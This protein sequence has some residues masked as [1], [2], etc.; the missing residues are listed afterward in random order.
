V[1]APL[2][3]EAG[4][5]EAWARPLALGAVIVVITYCSLI[6]GELAPKAIALRNPER[7]AAFVARPI[8][9]LSRLS[10]LPVRALTAST[11]AVVR[12]LGFGRSAES[13]FVSEE[14]VRYLV[15]EGAAKGIFEP[16]E[17]ELVQ[18]VFEFADTTV[19]EVMVPRVDIR[20][21]D[22]DTPP[23][24][25]LRAATAI[26]HSRIPVYRESIEHPVGVVIIK[27][28]LRSA[29]LGEAPSLPALM[30]PPLFVPE[31]ARISA[32]L[33]EFQRTRQNLAMVVD[34]Y[35]GVAGLVTVED[36]LEEIVGELREERESVSPLLSPLPGG[37]WVTD[38]AA[39]A[40]EVREALGLPPDESP[41]YNTVA[42]FV[43]HALGAIPRPGASV[44]ADGFRWTVVD[45]EGPR[46]TRVKI[47]RESR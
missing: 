28:L 24:D 3:V 20:A 46:V 12:L 31:T 36:V 27:D 14:E 10:A 42:G 21:L 9:W 40:W 6:L 23:A 7:I 34:E 13:P 4:V 30:H 44:V 37:A 26:G 5:A 2:L 1:L 47:E 17:R 25:V 33:A 38:G 22:V 8:L 29:A 39:P 18:N 15:T 19:R 45:V 35:G 32:L 16:V 43:I 41:A 11:R